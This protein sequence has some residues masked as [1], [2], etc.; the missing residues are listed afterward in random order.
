MYTQSRKLSSIT[1][2]G[3]DET[4]NEHTSYSYDELG[5]LIEKLLPN[6]VRQDCSYLP[7]GNIE[8]MT[9]FDKEGIC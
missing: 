8:S 1:T 3:I 7:G 5:R 9:S 4:S 2:K 6:G